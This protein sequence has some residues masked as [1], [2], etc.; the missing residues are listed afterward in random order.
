VDRTLK[1]ATIERKLAMVIIT[2]LFLTRVS[3][4]DRL[5]LPLIQLASDP[6]CH[7]DDGVSGISAGGKGVGLSAC[8]PRPSSSLQCRP[9][10]RALRSSGGTPAHA[11]EDDLR[12]HGH[13]D[14]LV[15]EEVL[16]EHE[17]AHEGDHRRH[18]C[19]LAC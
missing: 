3:L 18:S 8:S 5:Q 11:L 16:D 10:G 7:G 6:R 4:E 17:Y 13:E 1:K 12:A 9:W 2:S 19:A 15:G 14:E